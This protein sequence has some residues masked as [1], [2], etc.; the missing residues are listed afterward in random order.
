MSNVKL[1]MIILSVKI[2]AFKTIINHSLWMFYIAKKN[3]VYIINGKIHG[4]EYMEITSRI[5]HDIFH[6]FFALT[7]KI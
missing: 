5:E 7:R 2:I 6:L 1:F 3:V 4:Y